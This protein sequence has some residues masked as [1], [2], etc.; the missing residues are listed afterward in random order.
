MAYGGSEVQHGPF[1]AYPNPRRLHIQLL[2]DASLPLTHLMAGPVPAIFVCP[3]RVGKHPIQGWAKAAEALVSFARRF[4]PLPTRSAG[5]TAPQ[6]ARPDGTGNGGSCVVLNS[7]AGAAFCPP[8]R[9]HFTSG[10]LRRDTGGGHRDCSRCRQGYLPS[11]SGRNRR[12][13]RGRSG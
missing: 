7:N 5:A 8:Y 1:L 2:P 6:H 13:R 3:D 12:C 11:G 4:P 10:I 9:Q